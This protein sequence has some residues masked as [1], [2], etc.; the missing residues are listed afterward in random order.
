MKFFLQTADLGKNLLQCTFLHIVELI[1]RNMVIRGLALVEPV[2]LVGKT[3]LH[4]I[5]VGLGD[6]LVQLSANNFKN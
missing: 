1:Q 4:Q 2:N 5:I 6:I 3:D